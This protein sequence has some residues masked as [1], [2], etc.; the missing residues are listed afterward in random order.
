M[1]NFPPGPSQGDPHV[2]GGVTWIYDGTKW[3]KQAPTLTTGDINLFDPAH[4]ANSLPLP[5]TL[6]DVPPNTTS[7]YDVNRWFVSALTS[8]DDHFENGAL[9][10]GIH[11]SED[12][13]A[14]KVNGTLW[15]DSSPDSLT[16]FLY[17]HP[18]ESAPSGIWIPAAPPV[19]AIEEIEGLLQSLDDDVD[20]LEVRVLDLNTSGTEPPDVIQ[21]GFIW[22]DTTPGSQKAYIYGVDASNTKAWL[23]LSPA[24]VVNASAPADPTEGELWL[25]NNG[26]VL[27]IYTGSE[28]LPV[29]GLTQDVLDRLTTIEG[30]VSDNT[31][32]ISQLRLEVDNLATTRGKVARYKVDNTIGTPVVRSGEI[33]VNNPNYSNTTAVGF[34]LEDLDGTVTKPIADGDLIDFIDS[35]TEKLS[36]YKVTNASNAPTAVGVEYVSGDADFATNEEKQVYIYPQNEAGV[37]QQYVD[38]GL[39]L[40]ANKAG[41]TFTGSVTVS[42]QGN[43]NN[44]GVRFFMK[45]MNGDTNFTL[46]PTGVITGKNV[47][48]VNRD[49]GDCFQVKDSGGNTT[50]WKV[51]SDGMNTTPK[52]YLTGGADSTKDE[53]TIDVKQGI[54]GHLAYNNKVDLSWGA[55]T[56][57]IGRS[58]AT[59]DTDDTC[60][61]NLQHNHIVDVGRLRLQRTDKATG[62]ILSIEG[63]MQD[64]SISD[65]FFYAYRNADGTADAVNY[66]GRIDND[67]NIVNKGYV[68]DAVSAVDTTTFMP[69]TGGTFTG[70]VE[71]NRSN[72]AQIN[73]LK[74][75]NNDIQVDGAW[76]I[77]LQTDDGG[78]VKL[79]KTLEMTNKE[80]KGLGNPTTGTSAV[81]RDSLVGAKVAA[82]SSGSTNSGGFY[83]ISGRLF[84]KI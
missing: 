74:S 18:D 19:S 73:F 9:I 62:S 80:I 53:R 36:R 38:D 55:T 12:E 29:G 64:G 7:Q 39:A 1:A 25:N 47:I 31:D 20:A 16:L 42:T 54:A 82:S 58:V 37:T 33:S 79:S 69:K 67:Y 56:V 65:S 76:Y 4:P 3:Q 63:E 81:N 66:N 13:P 27:T 46:F 48:R 40:K 17:Y 68:D 50:K 32:D 30:D 60:T 72:N 21:D 41:D 78:K 2:D 11:V 10:A 5:Q 34:G 26:D 45:D 35:A 77:S 61:L 71:F 23:P 51:D 6:P 15:F 28:W 22:R 52:I 75:G 14:D 83:Y 43:A 8:L 44:D 70:L 49:A 24:A 59:G 57:W 84:Y